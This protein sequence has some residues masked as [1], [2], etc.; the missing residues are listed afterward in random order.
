MD[1]ETLQEVVD[2]LLSQNCAVNNLSRSL[3]L[4]ACWL[5]V[6]SVVDVARNETVDFRENVAISEFFEVFYFG[7]DEPNQ[8]TLVLQKELADVISDL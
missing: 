7:I 2:V 6:V 5:T 3:L 4:S 8:P 1:S